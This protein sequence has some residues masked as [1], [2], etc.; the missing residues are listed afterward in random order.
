MMQ[1]REKLLSLLFKHQ[2]NEEGTLAIWT[3]DSADEEDG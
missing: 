3:L 2:Q 1:K